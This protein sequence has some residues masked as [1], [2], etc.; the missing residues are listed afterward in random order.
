MLFLRLKYI[1]ILCFFAGSGA[2]AQNI[3]LYG[4]SAS[5]FSLGNATIATS[6]EMSALNNQAGILSVDKW[7]FQ[8][9]AMNLYGFSSLNLISAS[10]IYKLNANN[11]ISL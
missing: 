5:N 9:G 6:N 1:T 7:G 4:G 10:G 11:A 3:S 2:F 8:A